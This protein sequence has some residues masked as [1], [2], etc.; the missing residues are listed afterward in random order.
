MIRTKIVA[1]MGPA[2]SSAETLFS[3]FQAGCD[4]CRLNFSHGE[5]DQHLHTLRLI[6][7]AAARFDQPIAVLGDLCGP[8]IRLGKVADE[9]GVGGMPIAVGDELIIQRAPILG[10][11]GRVSTIYDHFVDDV[12]VGDRIFIEDGLLRFV[13]IDK[14][15]SQLKCQCTVGGILKSAKGINLPTTK[16]SI[17]S[18]TDRDWQCVDWAI[19]N[20]LDYLALSFVRKADDLHLIRQHLVNK[21]SDINLIAKIEKAEAITEIESIIDASDGL[22]VARGDLGV[23]MDLAD[24]PIIQKDLVRRCQVAGK[25]VIVATQMLQSMIEQSS[26][27]RAEV[28]DVANA[29]YDGT[30]AVMLSGETSVGKFPVGVVHTMAHIAE[31]TEQYLATL[32]PPRDARL[33]LKTLQMS[34]ALARGIWQMVE[35]LKAKLVIVWSQTGATAR[36]FSKYRFNVPIIALSSD[37]RALR[38]M[39]LHYGVIPQEMVPPD[40]LG[41]LVREVDRLAIDRKFAK[42]G[43]RI[44]IT[45]GASLGTPMALNGIVI[46]TLGENLSASPPDVSLRLDVGKDR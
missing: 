1:T 41:T 3:L 13:C 24:V 27:T 6:R 9:G 34:S 14:T 5:L 32:P 22:M 12:Q 17:P 11:N 8:K 20:D 18:I 26:P 15:Y 10:G 28:S 4:I 7:E 43:D 25:P 23:E 31:K 45:A 16:V 19:E 37:H 44:I 33:Q 30:D 29:I 21:V 38:R 36:I 46:H 2:V 40:D 42:P 39:A 35:D